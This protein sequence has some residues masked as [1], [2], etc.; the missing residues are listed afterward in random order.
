M[1]YAV[2]IHMLYFDCSDSHKKP[3][4]KQ[5][6]LF[7]CE[8]SKFESIQKVT[9]QRK[10]QI[11]Q[12]IPDFKIVF[13]GDSAVGKTSIIKR[14]HSNDF[15]PETPSTIGAAFVSKTVNSP[16]GEAILHLWDT[17]GQER[18]RSLVP[19]YARHSSIAIIVFDT[20]DPKSFNTVEDWV[21]RVKEDVT[22][23]CKILIAGN[24]CDLPPQFQKEKVDE[25]AKKNDMMVFYVSAKTG[26]GIDILFDTVTHS[27]PKTKFEISPP[28]PIPLTPEEPKTTCC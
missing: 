4:K 9:H 22:N 2:L 16:Y 28:P 18:Y 23:D 24:K 11:Q 7:Q 26:Q 1:N 13:V 6:P 20:S 19:M 3:S 15:S 14:Y 21:Q 27:L 10:M 8:I 5:E 25:W 17:A 12:K